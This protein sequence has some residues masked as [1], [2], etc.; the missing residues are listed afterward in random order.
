M[1]TRRWA[2]GDVVWFAALKLDGPSG[3]AAQ[4]LGYA[5]VD[6]EWRRKYPVDAPNLDRAWF[7]FGRS[8]DM[9]FRQAASSAPVPWQD[10]LA[11]LCRRADGIEWWLTGDAAAAVRGARVLPGDVGVRCAP[12][13]A[14]A[15]GD[16]MADW[17][18]EPVVPDAAGPP[19]PRG[20]AFHGA[21][22][23]WTGN[24]TPGQSASVPWHGWEIRVLGE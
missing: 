8:A 18:V 17:L 14:R 4:R 12:D 23:D 7:N 19:D 5:R 9:M 24:G 20:R 15:L 22:I 16:A 13:A 10:A 21:R 6:D 1:R 2:E 3:A 11:E